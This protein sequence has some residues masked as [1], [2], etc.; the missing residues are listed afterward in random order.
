M[1]NAIP[2]DA[3][4]WAA[5]LLGGGAGTF[6]LIKALNVWGQKLNLN[7]AADQANQ[8]M[9]VEMGA[10]LT[11]ARTTLREVQKDLDATR[12]QENEC[13]KRLAIVEAKVVTLTD[14]V[15]R[16]SRLALRSANP[17]IEPTQEFS[18]RMAVEM[19]ERAE[20]EKHK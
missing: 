3:I 12:D 20:K 7:L 19:A 18:S 14:E 1:S 17:G 4:E 8:A 13:R 2:A 15:D 6:V 9:R 10:M 16:L 5:K 11:D